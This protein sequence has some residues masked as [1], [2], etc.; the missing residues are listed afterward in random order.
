MVAFCIEKGETGMKICIL[1]SSLS[2]GGAEKWAS[3]IAGSLDSLGHDVSLVLLRHEMSFTVPKTVKVFVLDHSSIIASARTVWRLRALLRAERPDVLVSNGFYTGQFA[4]AAVIKS[5]TAWVCRIS[6]NTFR[7]GLTLKEKI[8][9]WWVD[10]CIGRAAAVVCNSQGLMRQVSKRW[11]DLGGKVSYLPNGLVFDEGRRDIGAHPA[12]TPHIVAAGRLSAEKRPDLFVAAL[13]ELHT[14][15]DFRA[16][17]FGDGPLYDEILDL[18]RAE[19]L[20]EH[21]ELPGFSDQLSEAIGDASC[22]V[23]CSDHEGSPNALAE[24]MALGI[25][26]VAT[27]CDFGP[28]ELLGDGR[29]L[30]V[31]VSNAGSLCDA[32]EQTLTDPQQACARAE[33]A[34]A[35]IDD[36]LDAGE[37]S[38]DW[39]ALF[40]SLR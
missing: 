22:F 7:E 15:C 31:E 3:I 30:L 5:N 23:L 34:R 8:A 38:K 2:Q 20:A 6:G 9:W 40:Q 13:K 39:V 32:I 12:E 18:I 10:R 33:R 25:P 35:W 4:G 1:S 27:D 19:G 28:G 36:H 26:A 17:W 37:V 21:I 24:A 29:G 11:P 16:T 14:R